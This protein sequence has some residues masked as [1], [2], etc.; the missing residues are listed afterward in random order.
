MLFER[1]ACTL[2]PGT[3]DTFWGLQR[4]WNTPTSFR[5][6]LERNIGYFS[7][8]A[9]SA[10]RIVH[11][12]RWNSYDQAKRHLAAIG[13]PER[14]EYFVRA[15]KLLVRQETAFLDPA[16]LPALNPIWGGGRDWLPGEPVFPGVADPTTPVVLESVLDFVPG[17]AAAYWDDYKAL[18]AQTAELAQRQLI[19]TFLLSTGPLH[20]VVQ[21]RWCASL[22]EADDHRRALAERP[23]WSAFADAYRPLVNESHTAVLKPSPVP[24]MRSLV[25]ADR[26]VSERSWSAACSSGKS[27]IPMNG[28]A[29][30]FAVRPDPFRR[31]PRKMGQQKA[32]Q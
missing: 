16:S 29:A 22:Q 1:R 7:T 28:I 4:K 15:R 3:L 31:P 6:L 19:G 27:A 10:E 14:M 30:G 21:Y 26:L 18:D 25:R 32:N 20:R 24:W 9:G 5:P 11:L 8:T 23:G 17:G 12:Y 2:R 13:T